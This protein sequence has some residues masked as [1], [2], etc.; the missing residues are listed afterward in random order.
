MTAD[1]PTPTPWTV[2]N[3]LSFAFGP[4]MPQPRDPMLHTANCIGECNGPRARAEAN[5]RFIVRAVNSHAAMLAALKDAESALNA[6][7]SMVETDNGPP[8]WDALRKDRSKVRAAIK[9]AEEQ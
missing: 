3:P 4:P 1:N 8:D 7:L 2:D 6:A 5:A 9:L